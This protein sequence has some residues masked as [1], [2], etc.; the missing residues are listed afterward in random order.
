MVAQACDNEGH[1]RPRSYTILASGLYT[2]PRFNVFYEP[3]AVIRDETGE[4]AYCTV[5][6]ANGNRKGDPFY[7]ASTPARH[8]YGS[9]L[10]EKGILRTRLVDQVDR[11]L[12][13]DRQVPK[14]ALV[15]AGFVRRWVTRWHPPAGTN[16]REG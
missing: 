15:I 13:G 4:H 6:D 5:C 3:A 7:K 10:P 14:L 11:A 16:P 8:S 12:A 2:C 1:R 9:I